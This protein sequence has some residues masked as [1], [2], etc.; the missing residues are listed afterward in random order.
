MDKLLGEW[1][2]EVTI[3]TGPLTVVFRFDMTDKDEF[4]GFLD[5][6]DTGAFSIPVTDVELSDD[7]LKFRIPNAQVESKLSNNEIVGEFKS[8]AGNPLPLSLKKE[9]HFN[10]FLTNPM[11]VQ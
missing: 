2:G 11:R 5:M 1:H 8:G 3:P 6:P 7:N 9:Y 4:V 10:R